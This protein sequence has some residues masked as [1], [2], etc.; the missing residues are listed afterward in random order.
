MEKLKKSFS[1]GKP[2][3]ALIIVFGIILIESGVLNALSGNTIMFQDGTI[4]EYLRLYVGVL[5]S[6][7]GVVTAVV[8]Y[9]LF[10]G[11]LRL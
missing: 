11:K 10:H 7:I 8:G 6:M 4:V 3:P 5:M 1:V 9:A 2:I